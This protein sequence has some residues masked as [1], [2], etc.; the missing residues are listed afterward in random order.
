MIYDTILDAVGSTP[1]VRLRK[2]PE[3]GSADILVKV[4]ALNVG[5]SIKSR[6]A[7][8]MIE[9]AEKEGLLAPDSIIVRMITFLTSI[10]Q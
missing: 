5:G 3:A 6:T 1:M 2:M 7:L 9:Q 10:A 4:E 8:N